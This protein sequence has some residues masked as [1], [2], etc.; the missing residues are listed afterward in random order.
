VP[1]KVNAVLTVRTYNGSFRSTFPVKTDDQNT[2]KRFTVTLGNGSAHLELESFGGAIAL[3]RPGEARPETERRRPRELKD[4]GDTG[5]GARGFG[6][7]HA[8]HLAMIDAQPEI[9]R[10]VDE[11]MRDAQPE[12]DR[13]VDEAMRELG[14]LFPMVH[15]VPRPTPQIRM[16]PPQPRPQP[17]IW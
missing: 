14:N 6:I 3:R 7:D 9:D 10:A 8:V 4:K 1:E 2:R 11:A 12:I 5:L 17:R 15:P 13:A 16:Q